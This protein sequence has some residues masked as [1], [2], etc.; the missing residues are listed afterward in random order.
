MGTDG[1]DRRHVVEVGASFRSTCIPIQGTNGKPSPNPA[2]TAYSR[3]E[4]AL[5]KPGTITQPA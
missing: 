2:Y 4:W 1:R 3:C 5:T